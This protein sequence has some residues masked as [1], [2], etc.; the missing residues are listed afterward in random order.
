MGSSHHYTGQELDLFAEAKH[1]KAYL[2]NNVARFLGPEVLEVGAGTGNNTIHLC[3]GRQRRWLCVEPD[4]RLLDR[5]SQ[6]INR[7]ADFPSVQTRLGTI[8][9]VRDES[10]DTILYVD[11]L[12]H[13]EDDRSELETASGLLKPGGVLVVA[14]P[15]HQ[16]LYSPF[17][18]AVGHFRRYSKKTLAAIGPS[19]LTLEQLY[20]IDSAGL[21]A[22]TGNLLLLRKSIPSIKQI[23]VW[24]NWLIP[25]AVRLDSLFRYRVGKTIIG[26]WRKS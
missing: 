22:S 16:W 18:K 25:I 26:V 2:S 9:S 12:E 8:E 19:H 3:P 20:Y 24:D 17:D 5:L 6:R 15:A 21:I 10:F 7:G 1:W 4:S 23:L 13:I 11:V 14:A